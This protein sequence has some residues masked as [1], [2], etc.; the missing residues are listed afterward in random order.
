MVPY[1]LSVLQG[2]ETYKP[3]PFI[4]FGALSIAAAIL[5]LLLPETLNRELPDT[6]ED[7]ENMGWGCARRSKAYNM[8]K[9]PETK[10]TKF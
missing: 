9:P 5:G 1:L 7:S 10:Q 2:A 3:L 4:L 8:S 6:L